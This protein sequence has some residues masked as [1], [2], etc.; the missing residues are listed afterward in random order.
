MTR[1]YTVDEPKYVLCY[2]LTNGTMNLVYLIPNEQLSTTE[3]DVEFYETQLEALYRI[4]DLGFVL[5]GKT[6]IQPHPFSL[7]NIELN[8]EE[9]IFLFIGEYNF[10]LFSDVAECQ[11]KINEINS[12]LDNTYITSTI[13]MTNY[14]DDTLEGYIIL[15]DDVVK[16][17]LTPTQISYIM[18]ISSADVK[19]SI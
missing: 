13:T 14:N 7:D 1:Y 6:N 12:C 2:S 9:L 17:C 19:L 10:L 16:S 15:V 18:T 11:D 4:L 5:M 8:T 3:P